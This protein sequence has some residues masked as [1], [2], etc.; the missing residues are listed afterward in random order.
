MTKEENGKMKVATFGPVAALLVL[1][2]A[3]A[4]P[5]TGAR[6]PGGVAA[7]SSGAQSAGAATGSGSGDTG[8]GG[9]GE[10]VDVRRPVDTRE[11]TDPALVLWYQQPATNWES[12]ALPIG[13]GRIGGMVFGDAANERV[14]LNEKTL[15]QGGPTTFGAYQTLGD[16][17]I[18]VPDTTGVSGYRRQLD[19]ENAV[20]SVSYTAG[21]KSFRRDFFV[22][23]PA[24]VM[25]VRLTSSAAAG[26]ISADFR[27]Q[28][29]HAQ[30]STSSGNRITIAGTLMTLAYEAQL[31][32]Q[33]EGGRVTSS[34][35]VVSVRGAD[36]VTLLLAADTSYDPDPASAR[37]T[38]DGPRARVTARIERAAAKPYQTL[39]SDHITDHR[40]L[41]NRVAL[42]LRQSRPTLATDALRRAYR[43]NVLAMDA[44][45]YQYGRYLLIASSRPG[46]PPANL[47]G[48]WNNSNT[49]PWNCDYHSNI[50]IQ[51]IYWPAETTNLG[52]C[53]EPLL[54]YLEKHQ[55]AWR[56]LAS[57]MKARG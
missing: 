2:P 20:A 1:G 25:V 48:I 38:R 3:C 49:P 31:L 9:A 6:G 52:E 35:G 27:L 54:E 17:H 12:Q 4:A 57:G 41:F 19:I 45:Y 16:L 15:W 39:R 34:G 46:S 14:Q 50:N 53:H 22:S 32:V 55:P 51:M 11:V 18:A 47:Q 29:G 44:L 24:E 13:N 56:A 5:G 42:D 40:R 7:Q 36:A 26:A 33:N 23:Y 8:T 21:G 37:Y 43:S 28:D 30:A 10:V